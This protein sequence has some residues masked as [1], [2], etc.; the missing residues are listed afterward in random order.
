MKVFLI[1]IK[2]TWKFQRCKKLIEISS[3]HPL[4]RYGLIYPL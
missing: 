4:K 2:D 1:Q 3:N